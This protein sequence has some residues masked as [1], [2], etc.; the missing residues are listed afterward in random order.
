MS[1]NIKHVV[2]D[3][4][5][6]T[7]TESVI[8]KATYEFVFYYENIYGNMHV[9]YHKQLVTNNLISMGYLHF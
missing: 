5:L 2:P 7:K 8:N 4:L 1:D 3:I 6:I 9:S